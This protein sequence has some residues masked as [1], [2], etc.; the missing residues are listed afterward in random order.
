MYM[1]ASTRVGLGA[2]TAIALGDLLA[3]YGVALP[4]SDLTDLTEIVVSRVEEKGVL[5]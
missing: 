2:R 4:P 5:A 3:S 1:N